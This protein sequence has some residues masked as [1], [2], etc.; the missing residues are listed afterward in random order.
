MKMKEKA[1]IA[2]AKEMTKE[3]EE[4]FNDLQVTRKHLES[5]KKENERL[6]KMLDDVSELKLELKSMF[7][8]LARGGLKTKDLEKRIKNIVNKVM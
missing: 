4:I 5:T 6:I 1:I 2:A 3:M 8:E 7:V